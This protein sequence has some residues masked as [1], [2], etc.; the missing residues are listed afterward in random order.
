LNKEIKEDTKRKKPIKV[1][2]NNG[3]SEVE[4]QREEDAIFLILNSEEKEQKVFK[5]SAHLLRIAVYKK[6]RR[7]PYSNI[8]TRNFSLD[9]ARNGNEKAVLFF[10]SEEV[11]LPFKELYGALKDQLRPEEIIRK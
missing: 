10:E 11:I 9:L 8:D 4:V 5:F 7:Y 1:L 2:N 3:W 6:E